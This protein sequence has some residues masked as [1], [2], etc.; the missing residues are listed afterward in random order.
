MTASLRDPEWIQEQ[1]IGSAER[2]GHSGLREDRLFLLRGGDRELIEGYFL[3]GRRLR[4]LARQHELAISTL[5]RRLQ[6]LLVNLRRDDYLV[7]WRLRRRQ[8]ELQREIAYQYFMQ[9]R[10]KQAIARGLDCQV[11]QVEMII[12]YLKELIVRERQSKSEV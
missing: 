4:N 5:H 2:I 10:P 3:H 8:T 11:R 7:L 1:S 12:A 9:S 6:R